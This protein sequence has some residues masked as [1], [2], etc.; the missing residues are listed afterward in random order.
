GGV[1]VWAGVGLLGG[2]A[3][4]VIA[5]DPGME[6]RLPSLFDGPLGPSLDSMLTALH[7]PPQFGHGGGG[8]EYLF[9]LL[10][11]IVVLVVG[12]IWRRRSMY[13]AALAASKRHANASAE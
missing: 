2:S 9:A 4:E 8:P 12:S 1:G 3:G 10:G 13:S 5:A 11:V 6:P 7:I